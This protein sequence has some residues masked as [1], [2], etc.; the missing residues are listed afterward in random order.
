MNRVYLTLEMELGRAG[1]V[2]RGDLTR[3][4]ERKLRELKPMFEELRRVGKRYR[5]KVMQ[6][7]HLDMV[8]ITDTDRVI[9]TVV[10]G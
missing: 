2:L 6:P 9:V 10:V 7:D 8:E 4:V 5:F 3:L 1:E